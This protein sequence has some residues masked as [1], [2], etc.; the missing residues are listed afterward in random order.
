[1]TQDEDEF[2]FDFTSN[3]LISSMS[4]NPGIDKV[5]NDFVVYGETENKHP[6][7]LRYTIDKKPTKYINW[8][9]VRYYASNEE[10]GDNS[11]RPVPTPPQGGGDYVNW[12]AGNDSLNLPTNE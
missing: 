2:I 6:I 11:E 9:W 5:K 10:I 1:V 7:H 8:N 4:I 12:R 3:E